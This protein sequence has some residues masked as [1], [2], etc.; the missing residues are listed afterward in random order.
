MTIQP[1]PVQR[2]LVPDQRPVAPEGFVEVSEAILSGLPHTMQ[3]DQDVR[4]ILFVP[5]GLAATW[6]D[7]DPTSVV[8]QSAGD[9]VAAAAGGEYPIADVTRAPARI[10]VK[11]GSAIV[12]SVPLAAGLRRTLPDS[13]D[14]ARG[15]R[16]E[17][18][19]LA[20][21]IRAGSLRGPGDFGARITLAWRRADKAEEIFLTPRVSPQLAARLEP[22]FRMQSELG[23]IEEAK[24][25]RFENKKVARR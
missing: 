2:F 10:A 1:I 24:L 17:L 19:I 16:V 14:S 7:V 4:L 6:R 12:A 9:L 22:Q 13:G 25:A 18:V 15:S 20:W 23:R 8:T 5:T 3:L 21:D 11:V